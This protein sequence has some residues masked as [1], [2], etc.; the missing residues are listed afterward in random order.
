MYAIVDIET[1]GGYAADNGITEIAILIHDGCGVV[2]SFTTL[3]NPGRPIPSFIESY[4]GITNEMVEHAPDFGAISEKVY[5]MLHDKVFVAHNVNF[6]YT[7]IRHH[8][9]LCGY[10]WHPKKLC[11]VR[12]GRK[13]FPG[14]AS[15]SL[16][17][18]CASLGISVQNRHRAFGDA[19]ATVT[20][21]ERILAAEAG[22]EAVKSFLKRGSGEANLPPNLPKEQFDALPASP[23]VYYFHDQ[24][25]KIIYVGKAVNIRKRVAQH[26]SGNTTSARRQDFLRDIHH[27]GFEATAT[28]LMALILES[29][30]IKKHWPQHNKSQKQ[31]EF[32]YGIYDYEDRNGYLRLCVDRVRKNIRPLHT[33]KRLPDAFNRLQQMVLEY[34]LCP[35]FCMTDSRKQP[36]D[37]HCCKGACR[38]EEEP[39]A[40][41]KRVMS[42]ISE[43]TAY[44]SYAIIDE[45]MSKDE[46]SCILVD[47]GRFYGMGYISSSIDLSDAWQIRSH[48]SPQKDNYFI[49]DLIGL[50]KHIPGKLIRFPVP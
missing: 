18:I 48:L 14:Y 24:K 7:F 35:K 44:E 33:F 15:Y 27:V 50:Q 21:F 8:L 3:I 49:R 32:S 30:E 2:D 28:E 45:G 13:V 39:D 1:T 9:A 6:D 43:L 25:G 38:R 19:E 40:Y 12:L 34:D 16:G 26:F 4:T 36:C 10:E 17:N 22:P 5:D 37:A 46:V 23:G 47:E 42:A 41:N 20:L 31:L 29:I 11:T